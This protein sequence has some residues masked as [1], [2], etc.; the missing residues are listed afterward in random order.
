MV[1]SVI[2]LSLRPVRPMRPDA[3]DGKCIFRDGCRDCGAAGRHHR[4]GWYVR[5]GYIGKNVGKGKSV[6]MLQSTRVRLNLVRDTRRELEQRW[7][8]EERKLSLTSQPITPD[9]AA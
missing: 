5:S 4:A 1:T 8:P 7:S 2:I 3:Q 9:W 6:V